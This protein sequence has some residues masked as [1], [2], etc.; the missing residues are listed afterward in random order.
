MFS[1]FL[2]ILTI[3]HIFTRTISYYRG[4]TVTI[5]VVAAIGA[6]PTET[7]NL[8][9]TL[10]NQR[11]LASIGQYMANALYQGATATTSQP[12][13]PDLGN[14][15]ASGNGPPTTPTMPM[16][17]SRS[18]M[19]VSHHETAMP[20][21]RPKSPKSPPRGIDAFSIS[22]WAPAKTA[23]AASSSMSQDLNPIW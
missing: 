21:P 3:F 13:R 12:M 5:A 6:I 7:T 10:V 19:N 20:I 9:P 1:L 4:L 2:D 16:M 14:Q 23:I 11:L 15:R 17:N 18:G 8:L 22:I